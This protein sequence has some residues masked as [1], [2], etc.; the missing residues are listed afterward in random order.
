MDDDN[1]NR[2]ANSGEHIRSIS[3]QSPLLQEMAEAPRSPWQR[4]KTTGQSIKEWLWGYDF[5]ISY[6]WASGGSY[7][8]KLAQRLQ[9]KRYEVFLDRAEYAMGDDW[10]IVGKRALDNTTRLVVIATR[11]AVT[12]SRPVEREVDRFRNRSRQVIPI[13]FGDRFADLVREDYPVLRQIND[14]QLYIEDDLVEGPSDT[15]IDQLIRTQRV[16]RRRNMRALLALIPV[17]AVIAFAAWATISRGQAISA[18][19]AAQGS[20]GAE[21]SERIAATTA[22]D[23]ANIARDEAEKGEYRAN[24]R[25]AQVASDSNEQSRFVDHL[26][27]Y[28]PRLRQHL[29]YRGFEWNYLWRKTRLHSPPLHQHLAKVTRLAWNPDGRRIAI[30]GEDNRTSVWDMN[31][32]KA[33]FTF[34][35]LGNEPESLGWSTDGK[36][37]IVG[38]TDN[39]SNYRLRVLKGDSG[40]TLHDFDKDIREIVHSAWSSTANRIAVVT[41][42]EVILCDASTGNR[43]PFL[44]HVQYSFGLAAWA[45]DGKRIA[46][47]I[48]GKS[49]GV[50]R[51]GS[52]SLERTIPVSESEIIELLWSADG[53]RLAVGTFEADYLL[54]L[55]S[56]KVITLPDDRKRRIRGM[57][58]SPDGAHL[59]TVFGA[60]HIKVWDAANGSEVQMFSGHERFIT[61]LAWSSDGQRLAT[62]SNDKSVRIW[63]VNTGQEVDRF[64]GDTGGMCL[65]AWSPDGRFVIGG[66][67]NGVVRAWAPELIANRHLPID[68]KNLPFDVVWSPDSSCF[69]GRS[70]DGITRIWDAETGAELQHLSESLE[71]F[72]SGSFDIQWTD[73]KGVLSLFPGPGPTGSEQQKALWWDATRDKILSSHDSGNRKVDWSMPSANHERVVVLYKEPDNTLEVWDLRSNTKQILPKPTVRI[74]QPRISPKGTFLATVQA[75]RI[76][77]VFDIAAHRQAFTVDMTKFKE[78]PCQVA[79]SPNEE[80][81]FVNTYD[82]HA[83]LCNASDGQPLQEIVG[84]PV[85]PLWSHDGNT[86]ADNDG[87]G[88]VRLWRMGNPITE[89]RIPINDSK[90]HVSVSWL[91]RGQRFVANHRVNYSEGCRAVIWDLDSGT[92]A[93]SLFGIDSGVGSHNWTPTGDRL[94]TPIKNKL[95]RIWNAPDGAE[96]MDITFKDDKEHRWHWSPDGNQFMTINDERIDIWDGRPIPEK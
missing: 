5:F 16:M 13:V 14:S 42:T 69:A 20:E 66:D 9:E 51:I 11:Q 93:F 63:S 68:G 15:T 86:F 31:S 43:E 90:L 83:V 91:P 88:S 71:G 79:W 58:W 41:P 57:A 92:Q 95:F 75:D 84:I 82:H 52:Q 39:L 32:E 59:A 27:K 24:V 36:L 7:A 89:H 23:Q 22:R 30:H 37:L 38:A 6:H 74:Q 29:K 26:W 76:V 87:E 33:Q 60:L 48:D 25:L 73:I 35:G 65:V 17:V 85:P 62:A 81:L 4:L 40:A 54:D 78:A 96:L 55:S 49:V 2:A 46:F 67:D 70:R 47:V 21:R 12:I 50:W 28:H 94:G 18:A 77:R 53:K 8:V 34:V 80:F 1:S 61:H 10:P 56:D 64:D 45:P 44:R 72:N 19:I 3:V